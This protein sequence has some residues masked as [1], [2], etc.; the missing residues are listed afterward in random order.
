MNITE[1]KKMRMNAK[2]NKDT[3]TASILTLVLGEYQT[4]EKRGDVPDLVSIA[5]KLIKSNTETMALRPDEKLVAE[6]VV[7]A[8]LLPKQMTEVELREAIIESG[9][10]NMGMLMKYLSANHANQYDKKL[11]SKI[12]NEPFLGNLDRKGKRNEVS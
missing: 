3:I 8:Q 4:K 1:L 5:Q 12:A 9:A 10:V 6:N 2:R 7:L 11:A